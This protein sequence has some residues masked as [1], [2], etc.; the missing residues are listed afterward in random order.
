MLGLGGR[1]QPRVEAKMLG[2]L[3]RLH[4]TA[5]VDLPSPISDV[6]LAV[7]TPAMRLR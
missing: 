3:A 6:S 1:M 2:L 4:S 5:L 7:V